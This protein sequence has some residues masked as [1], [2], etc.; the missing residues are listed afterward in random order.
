MAGTTGGIWTVANTNATITAGGILTG[1][2]T[3]TDTVKY[4]VSNICGIATATKLVNINTVPNSGTINGLSIGCAGNTIALSDAAGGGVWTS[5]NASLASV[6]S[7]GVVT[8][9]AAG[10]VTISYTITNIC[11]AT[12]ATHPITIKSVSDC[13]G[14]GGTAVYPVTTNDA[15]ELKVYPN[16]NNGSF[17][18]NLISGINEPVEVTITNVIGEKISQFTTTTNMVTNIILNKAAGIYILSANT[19]HGRFVAKITVE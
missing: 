1:V 3:G 16:P 4:T 11:S 13:S 14:G 19:I 17:N 2:N 12:S 15:D 18:M 8:L 6:A 10:T 5:S 9:F 7:S